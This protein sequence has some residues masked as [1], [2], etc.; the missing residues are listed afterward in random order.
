VQGSFADTQCAFWHHSHLLLV[1]DTLIKLEPARACRNRAL[2][3]TKEPYVCHNTALCSTKE[4]YLCYNRAI[5]ITSESTTPLTN[6][7]QRGHSSV[8]LSLMKTRFTY[9]RMLPVAS[10]NIFEPCVCCI[11]L[12]RVAARCSVL[13]WVAVGCSVLQRH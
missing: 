12:Q 1:D 6:L 11:V 4:T 10:S 9:S 13:Q 3:I 2:C 5:C 7:S 8:N